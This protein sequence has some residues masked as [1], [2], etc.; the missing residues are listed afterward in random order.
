MADWGYDVDW[1]IDTLIAME[2]TNIVIPSRSSRKVQRII[3]EEHYK[4]RNKV[5]RFF[6]RLKNWRRVATRYDKTAR[7]FNAFAA[8]A[9]AIINFTVNAA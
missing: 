5:E 3:D 9:A 6:S 7:N 4:Q 8:L 1:F 2:V